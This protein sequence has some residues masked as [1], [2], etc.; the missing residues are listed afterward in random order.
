MEGYNLYPDTLVLLGHTEELQGST[1]SGIVLATGD[2]DDRDTMF[3]LYSDY[4]LSGQH[5]SLLLFFYGDINSSGVY[6]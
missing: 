5:G 3:D 2:D 4:L 6:V 1:E